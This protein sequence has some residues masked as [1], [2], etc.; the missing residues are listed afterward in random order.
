MD[1]TTH[2]GGRVMAKSPPNLPA[3]G[4]RVSERGK[5]RSRLG[6]RT[7]MN[8]ETLWVTVEWDDNEGPRMTHL[9]TLNKEG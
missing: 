5:N 8:D 2:K 4:D 9:F 6:T 7:K 1:G 3:R